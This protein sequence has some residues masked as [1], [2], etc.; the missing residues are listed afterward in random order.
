MFMKHYAPTDGNQALNFG[1]GGGGGGGRAD[2][3]VEV[4]FL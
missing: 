1:A 2:V 4:K 3:N